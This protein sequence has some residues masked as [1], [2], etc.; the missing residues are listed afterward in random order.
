MI[1][2][3]VSGCLRNKLVLEYLFN[4]VAFRSSF[5]VFGY[6]AQASHVTRITLFQ[7]SFEELL[8]EKY[9]NTFNI[10]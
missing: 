5:G 10:Y 4:D 3:M 9:Q 2:V 7:T 6:I 1:V 8:Y